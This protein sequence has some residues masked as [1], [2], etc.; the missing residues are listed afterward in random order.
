[1]GFGPD[2]KNK[3]KAPEIG[4]KIGPAEKFEKNI[5]KPGKIVFSLHFSSYCR[6]EQLWDQ[7]RE[8]LLFLL[9]TGG[10]K[11]VFPKSVG[12]QGQKEKSSKETWCCLTTGKSAISRRCVHSILLNF[13]QWIFP[14]SPG[15]SVHFENNATLYRTEKHCRPQ[16]R[17][18]IGEKVQKIGFWHFSAYVVSRSRWLKF[19]VCSRGPASSQSVLFLFG[20]SCLI[21]GQSKKRRILFT[22]LGFF[23]FRSCVFWREEGA[24]QMQLKDLPRF[25][26][27]ESVWP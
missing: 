6:Q 5:S 10:P 14:F 21:S 11:P 12:L 19:G 8:P 7:F 25:E 16:N 24:H 2:A 3:K 4:P 22:S 13:L 1:M 9:Q 23:R 27:A 20:E 18:K 17:P 26:P 15:F